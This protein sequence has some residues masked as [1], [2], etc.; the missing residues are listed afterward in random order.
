MALAQ[1][2]ELAFLPLAP[3][4]TLSVSPCALLEPQSHTP[5]GIW[6][7]PPSGDLGK[8]LNV[9]ELRFFTHNMGLGMVSLPE[10]VVWMR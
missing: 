1:L 8:A 4:G 2:A 6:A 7:L 5:V 10:G 9:C 3:R